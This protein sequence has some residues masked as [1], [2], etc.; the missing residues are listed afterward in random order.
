MDTAKSLRNAVTPSG[1]VA[2]GLGPQPVSPFPQHF[3][4][5]GAQALSLLVG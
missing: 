4:T 3:D 5:R 1:K 2:S